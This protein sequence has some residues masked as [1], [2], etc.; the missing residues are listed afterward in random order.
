MPTLPLPGKFLRTPMNNRAFSLSFFRYFRAFTH[1]EMF[2][3]LSVLLISVAKLT[4]S[5]RILLLFHQNYLQ[6]QMLYTNYHGCCA[7]FQT[8]IKN[9]RVPHLKSTNLNR[10]L[11][12]TLTCCNIQDKQ[13]YCTMLVT[14]T[15][16]CDVTNVTYNVNKYHVVTNFLPRVLDVP[17]PQSVTTSG[18][19]HVP[20]CLLVP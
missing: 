9:Y 12:T 16:N 18:R 3:F 15:S 17:E 19:C 10:I 13:R 2:L 7:L 11:V 20:H 5:T 1:Y 4:Q 14:A 6:Y 8:T